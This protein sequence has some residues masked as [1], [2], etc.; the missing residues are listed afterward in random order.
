MKKIIRCLLKGKDLL[1]KTHPHTYGSKYW[2]DMRAIIINHW[3]FRGS[4]MLTP[5]WE[6]NGTKNTSNIN[7]H[8]DKSTTP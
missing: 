6:R 5:E 3:Y 7:T 8:T 4:Q 2:G 1:P